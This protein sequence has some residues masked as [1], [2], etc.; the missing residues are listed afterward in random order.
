MSDKKEETGLA[1]SYR[2]SLITYHSLNQL[3]R[4]VEQLAGGGGGVVVAEDGR[5][6]DEDFGAGGGDGGD[7]L[8]A[9]A[10]VHLDAHV[11]V[12]LAE[13]AGLMTTPAFAPRLRID[14]RVR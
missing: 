10:A 1:F 2:S 5:A 3:G 8:R 11:E 6:G 13:V 9:D 14:A 7:V 4:R 12:A